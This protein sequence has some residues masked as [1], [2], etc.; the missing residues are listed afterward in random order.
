MW[1]TGGRARGG[2]GIEASATRAEAHRKQQVAAATM[3]T[4][5]STVV[6]LAAA[7]AGMRD[8]PAAAATWRAH[9]NGATTLAHVCSVCAHAA[10]TVRDQSQTLAAGGTTLAL[11]AAATLVADGVWLHEEGS[12]DPLAE[13]PTPMRAHTATHLHARAATTCAAQQP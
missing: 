10:T 3:A 12:F 6:V 8:V 4:T 1:D 5:M 13:V 9:D 11:V 7:A 2:C